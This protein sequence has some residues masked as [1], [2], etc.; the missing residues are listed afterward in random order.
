MGLGFEFQNTLLVSADLRGLSFRKRRLVDLDFSGADLSGCDFRNAVFD[1]GSLKDANVK[2]AQ[3]EGA[4]LRRVDLG[5][6]EPGSVASFKK[7]TISF[8]QAAALAAALGLLV[9]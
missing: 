1:G 2:G 4:D 6:L 8:E 9:A 3:F 7:A 5:G